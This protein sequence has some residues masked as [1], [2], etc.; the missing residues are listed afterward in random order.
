[1]GALAAALSGLIFGI[2]LI[3]SGMANPAKVLNFLDFAGQWDP[4]LAFVMGGAIAITLPGYRLVHRRSGPA[5]HHMFHLP[6]ARDLDQRLI[7]GSATFGL[8]W[9]L[10]GFCPGPALTAL[11]LMDGGTQLFV[12]A[13]LIGIAI[14]AFQDR[15]PRPAM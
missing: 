6:G 14:A 8:G 7:L 3:L 1:M 4:S 11:P 2:G 5:L 12:A 10:A 13:M 9:G 15:A